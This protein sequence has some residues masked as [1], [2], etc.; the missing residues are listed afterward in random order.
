MVIAQKR[1]HP[2]FHERSKKKEL[3]SDGT[4]PRGRIERQVS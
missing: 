4:F 1:V 2:L 3:E